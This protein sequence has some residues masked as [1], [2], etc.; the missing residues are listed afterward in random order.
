M[1]IPLSLPVDCTLAAPAT[2]CL[3]AIFPTILWGLSPV[4]VK[5][6]LA[7]GGTT[8]QAL[9][10]ILAVDTGLLWIAT[11]LVHG[12]AAVLSLSPTALGLFAAAGVLGTALGRL[13]VYEGIDRLGAAITIAC[14]GTR[15]LFAA[16]LGVVA[17]GEWISLPTVLGVVVLTAG[18]VVLSLS[19]GGDVGGW[20]RRDLWF[21]LA[22][23]I[24]YATASALRRVGLQT[25]PTA[26]L[27]AVT[28]NETV[29]LLVVLGYV[30]A[31]GRTDDLR[32]PTKTYAL[33]AVSGV[34]VATGMASVFAAL[35]HPGG[36]VV[37]V[38]PL[39]AATPLF[40]TAFAYFLLQDIERVT[41]GIAVGAVVVVVGAVLVVLG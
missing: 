18:L 37:I 4:V 29:A 10:V 12:P 21:P 24:L 19:K 6:A 27:Q 32:G 2:V 30:L 5:Y 31:R 25:T 15:P 33:F 7:E 14:L 20:R 26:P 34:L 40:T 1:A 38:D 22:G 17:L 8:L 23:A 9:V 3:L 13:A 35:G 11:T 36:R 41:R 28:V 16:V 39:I